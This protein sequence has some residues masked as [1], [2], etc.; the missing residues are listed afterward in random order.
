MNLCAIIFTAWMLIE[1]G[2]AIAKH[3]RPVERKHT[4]WAT[5]II[6]GLMAL[7]LWGGGFYG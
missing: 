7:L 6:Y 5:I 3:G 4:A 1:I 2:Y